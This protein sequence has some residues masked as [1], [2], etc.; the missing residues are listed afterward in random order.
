MKIPVR[1]VERAVEWQNPRTLRW[2]VITSFISKEAA[3]S[4]A[5]YYSNCMYLGW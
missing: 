5:T 2:D 3:E 1:V 4:A